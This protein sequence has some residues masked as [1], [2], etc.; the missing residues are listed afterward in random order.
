MNKKIIIANWKSKPSTL[1]EAREL[2][3]AEIS[4]AEQYENVQTVI[5]PPDEF[6]EFLYSN[7]KLNLGAQDV[8]W[9]EN[10]KPTVLVSHVLAGHSDRRYGLGETD[11]VINQKLK[12]ALKAGII[13]I[14][15]VGE[16]EGESRENVLTTQLTK[17]LAGLS[18][19]QVSKVLFTY[20][21]VWAISTNLGGHPDTPE[22]ALGAIRFI[23]NFL[24]I[25]YQLSTINYQLLYGG[26]ISESNVADFLKHPEISG[27]VV[28]AA[29]LDAVKFEK[30]LE[31]TNNIN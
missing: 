20:E 29:S 24:L 9:P 18:S 12:M 25:N 17:D 3:K 5:C 21:P 19:G 14:L 6:L 31:I 2:F 28:G 22:S 27:V 15:L 13:P 8:F 30:I 26:S 23:Q 16:R 10:S 11:E 1:A 4:A 7:Y